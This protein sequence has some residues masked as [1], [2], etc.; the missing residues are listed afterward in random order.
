MRKIENPNLT[1]SDFMLLG[2]ICP[3]VVSCSHIHG[4]LGSP[5]SKKKKKETLRGTH[6]R[7]D[8]E[9]KSA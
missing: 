1:V 8:V 7:V 5:K 4:C 9:I 3:G 2:R 6:L